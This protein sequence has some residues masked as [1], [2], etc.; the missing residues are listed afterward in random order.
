MLLLLILLAQPQ[1]QPAA[2]ATAAVADDAVARKLAELKRQQDERIAREKAVA[3]LQSVAAARHRQQ[4]EAAWRQALPVIQAGG[5]EGAEAL[6]LLRATY[7]NHPMGNPLAAEMATAGNPE[8]R[9]I[10]MMEDMGTLIDA[11][12]NNCDRMGDRLSAFLDAHKHT[13][14]DVKAFSER[15]TPA[16]KKASED[17]YKVRAQAAGEKMMR[18]VMAC[19]SNERVKAAMSKMKM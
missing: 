18:G 19:M 9:A 3:N 16:Q 17:K 7:D 8:E 10:S 6:R 1:S 4:V 15:Q 5:P 13:I 12:K 14:R 2:P 11:E